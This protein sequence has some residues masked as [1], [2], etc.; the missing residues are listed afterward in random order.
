EGIE[1]RR[2]GPNLFV[3][4]G[5]GAPAAPGPAPPQP[6]GRPLEQ[7]EQ[8]LA[9]ARQSGDRGAEAT[10]LADLGIAQLREGNDGVAGV[11]GA[12]GAARWAAAPRSATCWA[13]SGWRP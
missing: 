4:S 5:V 6:E 7:A 2:L 12:G 11:G 13:T 1:I 10:A 8:L 9:R 3:V